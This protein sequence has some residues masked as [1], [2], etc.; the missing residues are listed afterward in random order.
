MSNIERAEAEQRSP[1]MGPP[2]PP[3]TLGIGKD[4]AYAPPAMTVTVS[5]ARASAAPMGPPPPPT[6]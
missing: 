2:P 4:A 5:A 1:R 6:V 3:G